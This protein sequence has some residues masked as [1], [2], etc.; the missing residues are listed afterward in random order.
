MKSIIYIL[1]GIF[2]IIGAVKILAITNNEI[3]TLY[4]EDRAYHHDSNYKMGDALRYGD[5]EY[6]RKEQKNEII[7]ISLIY[8]GLII[9]LLFIT[10]AIKTKEQD[11]ELDSSNYMNKSDAKE[12]ENKVNKTNQNMNKGINLGAGIQY[13]KLAESANGCYMLLQDIKTAINIGDDKPDHLLYTCY[14]VRNEIL[15][16]IDKYKWDLNTP[17]VVPMMP[18]E[19]KTLQ[20]ALNILNQNINTCAERISYEEECQEILNRKDFYYEF[21]QRIP[22]HARGHK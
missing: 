19:N 11:E 13:Q 9:A 16:R 6:E 7:K 14:L 2:F 17:L 12:F 3:E 10:T 22:P 1:V 5:G 20:V 15:D 4:H 8:G 18:G 21:E